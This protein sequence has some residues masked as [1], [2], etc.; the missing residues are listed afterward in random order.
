MARTGPITRTELAAAFGRVRTASQSPGADRVTPEEFEAHLD[1]HLEGLETALATGTWSPDA[2]LR[3]PIAKA[4]GGTRRLA[5][6]TV[7]DRVVIECLRR[8]L[9]PVIEPTLSDAAFAFRPGRSARAAVDTLSEAVEDGA[10]YVLQG[11]IRAFFDRIPLDRLL[12]Q[13]RRHVADEPTLEATHRLLHGHAT[14]DR[15]GL[16]Q[17]SA[18]SPLLSNLYLTPVDRAM[19]SARYRFIRYADD[20]AVPTRE[21]DAASAA[22]R[23]LQRELDRLGLSLVQDKTRVAS[24][25]RGVTWLGFHIGPDG[26][27]VSSGAVDSLRARIEAAA[28]EAPT[29]SLRGRLEP[30][31]RGWVQY[32]DTP[33]PDG[34][35]LGPHGDLVRA[36]IEEH[37]RAGTV[38]ARGHSAT[39]PDD[40]E[41]DVGAPTAPGGPPDTNREAIDDLLDAADAL[42]TQ[43]DFAAA[44]A[45]WREAD[46]LRRRVPEDPPPDEPTRRW[47]PDLLDAFLGLF[48]A[49]QEAFERVSRRRGHGTDGR[50]A[51]V[52]VE[53]PPGHADARAHL[54]GE[55]S[56]AVRPRLPDGTSMLGV[57]DIDAAGDAS[58]AAAQAFAEAVR[59]VARSQGVEVLVEETGG[60]G[61][62]VWCPL[63]EPVPA[64]RLGRW[65]DALQASA[66]EPA[67]GIRVER[68]PATD[69]EPDLAS[70]AMTLPLG[71]H[72]RTGDRSTL[73]HAHGTVDDALAGLLS[74]ET[75]PPS[76]V[77]MPTAPVADGESEPH[78]VP[79][80][81]PDWASFGV[82]VERVMAGCAVLRHLAD[83]A[84][85]VG[86]LDHSE[87]LSLL[88]S[89][90]H[91]GK[92]GERAIHAIVGKCRNYDVRETD[93]QIRR[94]TG[95]PIGCRRLKQKHADGALEAAC[96]CEFGDVR[97]RGGY[98]TP[99]L[100]AG[101]FR[102]RWKRI[103]QGRDRVREEARQAERPPARAVT[104]PSPLPRASDEEARGV[105][106]RGIPPHDWA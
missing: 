5:I 11:D 84:A 80:A 95:I 31:V 50:P 74:V 16:A 9:E 2:L 43:G 79:A 98:P 34:V 36:L 23:H 38:A 101:G 6:P 29:A 96:V 102:R 70:Q 7:R 40:A 56:M 104:E 63:S 78:T 28:R 20:L 35:T 58:A 97:R 82:A 66:G 85:T 52:E 19:E 61:V 100:H 3:V 14:T 99:L 103:L 77:A 22:L 88:Y 81:L 105:L 53:C 18:L 8:R 4:R 92:A 54:S 83:K 59:T 75:T 45:R 13:L 72:R 49:G 42:A 47:D 62:H 12:E 37:S 64:D 69:D 48:C 91:L 57:L 27:H 24:V 21:H 44:D 94:L 41:V 86:H 10:V 51:S 26:C 55:A 15:H 106:V 93:R 87:R 39:S 32:F 71:V 68:L 33:L 76:H 25:A 90:G 46:H 89:L 30:L 73:H 60:R 67:E 65:L 17:G 1:Q